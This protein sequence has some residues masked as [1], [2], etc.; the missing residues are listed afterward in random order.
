MLLIIVVIIEEAVKML[1]HRRGRE[2]SLTHISIIFVELSIKSV[3]Y[4]AVFFSLI[5]TNE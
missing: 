4:S 2:G 1:F 3:I 5:E